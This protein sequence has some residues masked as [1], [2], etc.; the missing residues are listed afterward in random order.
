MHKSKKLFISIYLLGFLWAF[1][2]ALP[3]YIQSSYLET[4]AGVHYVGLY[5]TLATF[6]TLFAIFYFPRF[7]KRFHNYPVAFTT[8]SALFVSTVVLSQSGNRWVVLFF[9]IVYTVSFDLIAINMDIFLKDITT[10][11]EMGRVRTAFL[12]ATNIAWVLAPLLMGQIASGGDYTLVYLGAALALV[13]ALLILAS[14]RRN[15]KDGINYRSRRWAD[16]WAAFRCNKNLAKIFTV[17]YFLHFFYCIM[18]VYTPIYLHQYK[19]FDWPQIGIMFTIML[20]PFVILEFPAGTIA[21]RYLGEQEILTLGLLIMMVATGSMFFIQSANFIVWAAVLFI[22][23]VGASLV[24]AMQDVYFFKIVDKQDMD[25]I[26]LFR[27]VR[28]AAWLSGSLF[29]VVV[30]EFFPLQYLYLFLAVF[31]M[32]ALRPA[33]ILKDTK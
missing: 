33:L 7:I 15:L 9:F 18:V 6:L 11:R 28:P 20:V 25:L 16:L 32:V 30:L 26:D 1:A 2:G 23:R 19:G 24:E 3:S 14:Q 12:T 4:F 10:M 17:T 13:P 5:W 22:S 29:A 27:D 31:L 8:L 21:D